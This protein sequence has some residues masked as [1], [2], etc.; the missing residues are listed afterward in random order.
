MD[1]DQD[2]VAHDYVKFTL[3]M[4][5][6]YDE[7]A[8]EELE[9]LAEYVSGRMSEG[10]DADRLLQSLVEAVLAIIDHND[11]ASGYLH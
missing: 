4:P 5:L 11:M 3:G 10:V 1:D 6:V 9:A 7:E 8:A 2:D